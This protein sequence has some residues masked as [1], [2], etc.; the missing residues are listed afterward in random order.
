MIKKSAEKD[1]KLTLTVA[2]HNV[3]ILQRLVATGIVV[4]SQSVGIM[5]LS[6][7]MGLVPNASITELLG[8]TSELVSF[9]SAPSFRKLGSKVDA[10]L[11]HFIRGVSTANSSARRGHVSKEKS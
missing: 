3:M 4:L 8:L 2:V 10:K 6:T 1:K 11:V 7:L 5:K 9:Q